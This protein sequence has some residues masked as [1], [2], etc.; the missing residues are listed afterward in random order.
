MFEEIYKCKMCGE[1]IEKEFIQKK[2]A[3]S[4]LL[5]PKDKIRHLCKSGDLGVAEFIGYKKIDI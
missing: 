1:K 2:E 3:D 4:N 5:E